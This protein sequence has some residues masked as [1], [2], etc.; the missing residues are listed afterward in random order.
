M[1]TMLKSLCLLAGCL[2]ALPASAQLTSFP[3]EYC[4]DGQCYRG[5]S[6]YST[7]AP[8]RTT[9]RNVVAPVRAVTRRV[10]HSAPVQRVR[11]VARRGLLGRTTYTRTYV[12]PTSGYGSSGTTTTYRTSSAGSY[13]SYSAPVTEVVQEE[14]AEEEAETYG[15]SG[16]NCA[17]RLQAIEARLKKLEND[18]LGNSLP[19]PPVSEVPIKDERLLA[20]L[21]KLETDHTLVALK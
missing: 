15:S 21:R 9:V 3:G 2:A 12:A 16:C 10:V 8:V 11:W 14:P 7:Y 4:V 5:Y 19:V 20:A 13:S 18:R 17:E 1:N 6:S